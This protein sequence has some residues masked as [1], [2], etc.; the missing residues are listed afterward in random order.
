MSKDDNEKC[1]L[2]IDGKGRATKARYTRR[3]SHDGV[4]RKF[5]YEE[6]EIEVT[7]SNPAKS[8]PLKE[9][10]L[11]LRKQTLLNSQF[12]QLMEKSKK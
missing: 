8:L 1:E 2:I 7:A 3:F 12:Y 11:E 5:E 9:T 10:F 4:G 6:L